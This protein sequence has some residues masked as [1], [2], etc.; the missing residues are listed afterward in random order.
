VGKDNYHILD[1][2]EAEPF[3][4][5]DQHPGP[6]QTM[7][8]NFAVEFYQMWLAGECSGNTCLHAGCLSD[9]TP[10]DISD[11]SVARTN[12][13]IPLTPLV[14][15]DKSMETQFTNWVSRYSQSQAELVACIAYMTAL[16]NQTDHQGDETDFPIVSWCQ[17]RYMLVDSA[18]VSTGIMSGILAAEAILVLVG[19][20]PLVFIFR[21]LVQTR[22]KRMLHAG[23]DWFIY[24]SQLDPIG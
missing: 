19:I 2:L 17:C 15:A 10:F 9:S 22:R 24:R 14:C 7:L 20:F 6:E 11:K 1:E 13:T 23:N 3:A 16:F 12:I 8:H 21:S 4:Y 5:W 18:K